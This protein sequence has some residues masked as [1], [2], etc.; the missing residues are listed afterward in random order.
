M[1]GRAKDGYTAGQG[2]LESITRTTAT[3]QCGGEDI[4]DSLVF[5]F[6]SFTTIGYGSHPRA[7]TDWDVQARAAVRALR[8]LRLLS[9]FALACRRAPSSSR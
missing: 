1:E 5:Q 9:R 6:T 7:F 3:E 8:L 2:E 4:L